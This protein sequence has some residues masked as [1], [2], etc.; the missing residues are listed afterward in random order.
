MARRL[1]A[2]ASV[3]GVDD[4]TFGSNEFTRPNTSF[5]RETILGDSQPQN[6]LDLAVRWGGEVRLELSL[7]GQ[8]LDNGDVRVAGAALLFEGTSEESD[9]LDGRTDFTVLV[10]R[11]RNAG[12]VQTVR[13]T[14]EGGDFAEITLAFNNAL[15]ED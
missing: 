5:T 2:S 7:I 3:F 10:P 15:V 13:N 6:V 12:T 4:E 11:G 14:D 1:T 8:V 9:D